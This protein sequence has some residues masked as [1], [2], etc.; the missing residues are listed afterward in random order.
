MNSR[1]LTLILAVVIGVGIGVTAVSRLKSDGPTVNESQQPVARVADER[2]AQGVSG[3]VDLEQLSQIVESL[4]QILD[5]EIGERRA[6][7]EQLEEVRTEVASL[8]GFPGGR[9]DDVVSRTVE[10]QVDTSREGRLAAAGFS[11]QEMETIRQFEGQALMRQVELDDQ[12][13]REGWVNTPRYNREMTQLF[14]GANSI[15]QYL[16]DD[17][18]DRYL[19]ANGR[20]NRIAVGTVI[21]T[22]PAEQAGI[23][24]GD[25][26]KSYGGERVFSSQQLT[27]LRSAGKSGSSVT[28]EIIRDGQLM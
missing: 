17:G 18:Y 15:R 26:I 10:D 5:E 13:R 12:A 1:V 11:P 3:E 4:A 24:M 6:L 19:F 25:V 20:P 9:T 16:G 22:S 27:E 8:R 14:G 23:Q 21:P 28:V 7:E 2:L